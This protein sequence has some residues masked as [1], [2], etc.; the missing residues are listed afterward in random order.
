MVT[1]TE[2]GELVG[3]VGELSVAKASEEEDP[4]C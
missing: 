3:E 2:S 4:G 1:P